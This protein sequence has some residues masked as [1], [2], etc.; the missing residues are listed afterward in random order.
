MKFALQLVLL[1]VIS[2]A[3]GARVWLFLAPETFWQRVVASIPSLTISGIV[4]VI[5]VFVFAE[6]FE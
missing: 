2:A 6:Y 5:L 1:L 4:A 3:F